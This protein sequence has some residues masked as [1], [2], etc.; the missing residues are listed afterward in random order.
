MIRG[1]ARRIALAVLAAAVVGGSGAAVASLSVYRSLGREELPK[2][3]PRRDGI[4][5]RLCLLAPREFR[6][7]TALYELGAYD[8]ATLVP[9]S[10]GARPLPA[11]M[12][13]PDV[14]GTVVLEESWAGAAFATR[15]AASGPCSLM[16]LRWPGGLMPTGFM[17]RFA[18]FASAALVLLGVGLTA[19]VVLPFLGAVARVR[20]AAAGVGSPRYRSARERRFDDLDAI[21]A[22]LDFAHAEIVEAK[23]LL[24]ARHAALED[25]LRAVAHDVRTPLASLSLTLESLDGLPVDARREAVGRALDD[26]VFLGGLAEN[27]ALEARFRERHG[28][29][30]ARTDLVELVRRVV[31]RFRALSRRMGGRVQASLGDAPLVVACDPVM[32]EQA[33]SNLVHN[34]LVH[35]G[36]QV[37]VTVALDPAGGGG[38]TLRVVDDGP[39]FSAAAAEAFRAG[40]PSVPTPTGH[41][42]GLVIVSTAVALHGWRV[43]LETSAE[44]SAVSIEAPGEPSRVEA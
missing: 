7:I 37:T 34:A 30:R 18:L 31:T 28:P 29:E 39:G 27:L 40:A 24:E 23:A 21:S 33:L 6:V 25:H 19:W 4:E 36:P 8:A 12:V 1:T 5:H 43:T 16:V 3:L 38:A 26:V 41:G 10:P 15:L 9:D 42:R 14:G 2:R 22:A 44:G 35:G 20:V 17:A 11:D 32:I 13:T